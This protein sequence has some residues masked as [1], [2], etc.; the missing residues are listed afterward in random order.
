MDKDG[1]LGWLTRLDFGSDQRPSRHIQD[2]FS[3]FML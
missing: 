3:I 2:G 1:S